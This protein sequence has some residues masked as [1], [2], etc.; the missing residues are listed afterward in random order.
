L[1]SLEGKRRR[2]EEERQQREDIKRQRIKEQKNLPEAIMQVNKYARS[3]PPLVPRD[4]SRSFTF[5]CDCPY[6]D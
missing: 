4:S 3:P 1:A 2:E 6:A 5:P